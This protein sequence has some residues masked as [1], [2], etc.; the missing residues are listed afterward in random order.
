MD[1][2]I[3]EWS[4]LLAA[5]LSTSEE[6]QATLHQIEHFL[7][8]ICCRPSP[9]P[10]SSSSSLDQPLPFLGAD[11]VVA[12]AFWSLQNNAGFN[13]AECLLHLLA[14]L[15]ILLQQEL[16][17]YQ[18]SQGLRTTSAATYSDTESKRV[19]SLVDEACT[20]LTV[21]QGLTLSHSNTK[22][23]CERK[24]WLELLLSI[25]LSDYSTDLLPSMLSSPSSSA[26]PPIGA[27]VTPSTS[28]APL[29]SLPS[30]FALEMLMCILVESKQ[31]QTTFSEIG[32]LQQIVELS[33]RCG[34][35]VSSALGAGQGSSKPHLSPFQLDALKQT[36]L[37]C[38]EFRYFVSQLQRGKEATAKDLDFTG[39]AAGDARGTQIAGSVRPSRQM[40]SRSTSPDSDSSSAT[41]R[42]DVP[43]TSREESQR[44]PRA[45]RKRASVLFA[46]AP[47]SSHSRDDSRRVQSGNVSARPEGTERRRP[48]R[49]TKSVVE[50]R[51]QGV[52]GR[53]GA[54]S[55]GEARSTARQAAPE[56]PGSRRRRVD[57]DLDH[58]RA[59]PP[60]SSPSKRHSAT[61]AQPPLHLPKIK[62]TG[63]TRSTGN[64]PGIVARFEAREQAARLPPMA[65]EETNEAPSRRRSGTDAPLPV[66]AARQASSSPLKPRRN[67]GLHHESAHIFGPPAALVDSSK[68]LSRRERPDASET[69]RRYRGGAEDRENESPPLP[70][71]SAAMFAT[72]SRRVPPSPA[73]RRAQMARARSLS[74]QKP[75]RI[76]QSPDPAAVTSCGKTED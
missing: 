70:A 43:S 2:R 62:G 33:H 50:L 32:G 45:P 69:H 17:L 49:A 24:C 60:T 11:S 21:L 61:A 28:S 14:R 56:S 39:T 42:D 72:M 38:L 25:T 35:A 67:G 10:S 48:L 15:H 52:R 40:P 6:R 71:T 66:L 7:A 73:V 3:V 65:F 36:D 20:A 54:E 74:P 46:P 19:R 1:R 41:V 34:D 58:A 12:E 47:P 23:I 68:V 37:H 75:Y 31:A 30:V 27:T 8:S 63:I 64:G 22:R 59:G 13:I 44:T 55:H 18:L 5:P 16:A 53:A 76:R 4:D 57:P 26:S 29:V 51:S 9:P